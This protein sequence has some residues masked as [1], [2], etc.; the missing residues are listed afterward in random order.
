MLSA[1]AQKLFYQ[2]GPADTH[3]LHVH[4]NPNWQNAMKQNQQVQ[5]V[6]VD[7]PTILSIIPLHSKYIVCLDVGYN[8]TR[9]EN[10][11]ITNLP[12]HDKV[13]L[14]DTSPSSKLPNERVGWQVVDWIDGDS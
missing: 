13:I 8:L 1:D 14:Q 7:K 3:N 2:G 4:M 11:I 5:E 9:Q 10:R 12:L 6:G